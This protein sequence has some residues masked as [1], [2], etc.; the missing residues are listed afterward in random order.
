MNL[1]TSSPP[2]DLRAVLSP[3]T[4]GHESKLPNLSL[5]GLGRRQDRKAYLTGYHEHGEDED[6]AGFGHWEPAGLL[7]G[8]EDGSVQ[9]GLGG[10]GGGSCG[11]WEVLHG[12]GLCTTVPG[13][14]LCPPLLVPAP[15]PASPECMVGRCPC[16]M[17]DGGSP[18][19]V[20]SYLGPKR[21]L[22]FSLLLEGIH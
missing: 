9:A 1:L 22:S 18:C 19:T 10:A 6:E 12:S 4:Q 2:L 7:E 11:Y 3:D 20:K 14:L 5:G 15:I 21:G 13:P 16:D 8:K 17:D